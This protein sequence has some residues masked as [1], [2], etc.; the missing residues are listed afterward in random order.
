MSKRIRV[1]T[2]RTTTTRS[3]SVMPDILL[4]GGSIQV[5]QNRLPIFESL[6]PNAEIEARSKNGRPSFFLKSFEYSSLPIAIPK[7][8]EWSEEEYNEETLEWDV[9]NT[10]DNEL[11]ALILLKANCKTNLR[12]PM[13]KEYWKK[14][15]AAGRL[16]SKE[17]FVQ[18]ERLR[19]DF[20]KDYD[21]E[22]S[23]ARIILV[24]KS[25]KFQRDQY[26]YLVAIANGG[27]FEYVLARSDGRPN[28]YRVECK[29]SNIF[30]IDP[31]AEVT[32]S[33]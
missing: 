11:G 16:R 4:N 17:T 5:G 2:I 31:R 13:D 9:V 18:K 28:T 33:E 21:I 29:D 6:F 27:A 30:L 8:F 32:L 14:W 25:K 22:N 26:E 3:E 23:G 10:Y 15:V 12:C 19:E 7:R 24:N 1:Y 20:P